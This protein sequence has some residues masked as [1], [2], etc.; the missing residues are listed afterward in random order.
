LEN[1]YTKPKFLLVGITLGIKYMKYGEYV[2]GDERRGCKLMF[3]FP[4]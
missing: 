1:D 4:T 2:S 3:L